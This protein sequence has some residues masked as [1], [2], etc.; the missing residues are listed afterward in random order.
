MIPLP[1]PPQ[2]HNVI[3]H[4][5]RHHATEQFPAE[6]GVNLPVNVW[7]WGKSGN[8]DL[9]LMRLTRQAGWMLQLKPSVYPVDQVAP[10]REQ[11]FQVRVRQKRFPV[12]AYRITGGPLKGKYIL[13]NG[14]NGFLAVLVPEYSRALASRIPQGTDRQL[15]QPL[16]AYL[17]ERAAFCALPQVTCRRGVR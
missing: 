5:E 15:A 3:L 2:L 11:L 1:L 10:F 13:T 4:P 7:S 9:S 14:W 17:T 12:T 16:N 8:P 6:V